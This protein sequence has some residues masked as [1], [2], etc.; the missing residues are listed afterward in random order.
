MDGAVLQVEAEEEVD[1]VAEAAGD[2]G[3]DMWKA[4]VDREE[5]AFCSNRVSSLISTVRTSS[6]ECR[7]RVV[8]VV[9]D[10]TAGESVGLE[11]T[12]RSGVARPCR[13]GIIK[14]N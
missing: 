6:F 2:G 14:V 12:D 5:A 13:K 10:T 8:A 11:G 1:E 3:L 7:W 4:R 9:C